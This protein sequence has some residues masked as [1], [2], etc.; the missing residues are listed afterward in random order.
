MKKLFFLLFIF[1][2][3]AFAAINI[4]TASLEELKTLNGIGEEKAK[5]ILAYRQDQNFTSIED[6]KKVKG[7]GSKIFDKIKDSIV[8][9]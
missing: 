6:L 8:V 2:N 5:A 1:A 4:N 9:E 7:I 3:F